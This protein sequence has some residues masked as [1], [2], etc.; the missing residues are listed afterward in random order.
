MTLSP[1]PGPLRPSRSIGKLRIFKSPNKNLGSPQPSPTPSPQPDSFKNL[2][3]LPKAPPLTYSDMN[4]AKH[5]HV[6]PALLVTPPSTPQKHDKG[7]KEGKVTTVRSSTLTS[8]H[9]VFTSSPRTVRG[10]PA[11]LRPNPPYQTSRPLPQRKRSMAEKI[12]NLPGVA[13]VV[14]TM[15]QMAHSFGGV[16]C[17]KFRRQL[18]TV[19]QTRFDDRGVP[20]NAVRLRRGQL[21]LLPSFHGPSHQVSHL[22]GLPLRSQAVGNI[23]HHTN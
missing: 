18:T 11:P 22:P 4:V 19:R 1:S 12:E 14:G 23:K 15:D 17:T 21:P 9:N 6:P 5:D 2:P 3:P 20:P 13:Q 8:T 7:G 10:S 16:S